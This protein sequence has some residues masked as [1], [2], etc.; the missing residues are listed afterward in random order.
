MIGWS[1]ISHFEELNNHRE[2]LYHAMEVNTPQLHVV[3]L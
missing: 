3:Y 1:K 2:I